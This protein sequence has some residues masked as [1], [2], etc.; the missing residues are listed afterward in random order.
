MNTVLV[1]LL[2]HAFANN[3]PK[4]IYGDDPLT[5][6]GDF[7]TPNE[8]YFA[9]VDYV[10]NRAAEKGI[11]VLL[12][13]TYLGDGGGS[14][15]W[16]QEMSGNGTAKL[17]ALGQYV[18]NRYKAF[19]NILRVEG[20]HYNAPNKALVRAVAEGNKSVDDKPHTYHGSRG[21]SAMQWMAGESW[22]NVNNIYTDV[23]TVVNAAFGE[24][25]RSTAPFFLIEAN[26]EGMYS[27]TEETVRLQAYQAVLSGASGHL[28]GNYP[29]WDFSSGW[30]NA[31]NS[32]GARSMK[33]IAGVFAPR[34][35]WTLIPDTSNTTLTAGASSGSDRAVAARASDGAFAIAY[36]PSL[37]SLT[38]DMSKLAGPK[39]KAQWVD[40]ASGALTAVAG[41]PFTAFGAQSLRP[42]GANS[43]GYSDWV[44]LLESTP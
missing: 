24:Y 1:N 22:L 6:A 4:N 25:A 27:T 17:T 3:P 14:Q 44:L 34:A 42:A 38:I 26:Y 18:G 5:T 39:V 15:G 37:R 11:L 40:P 19:K 7:S 29:V 41:S 43:S 28:M 36:M 9:N 30:S 33:H 13:P 31:L 35:W 21:T 10:I 32:A 8:R 23:S 2:E 20:G 12:T 16:Y